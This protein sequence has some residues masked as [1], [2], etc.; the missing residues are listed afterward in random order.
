MENKPDSK[1][2][3][4]CR[5][6]TAIE[7]VNPVRARPAQIGIASRERDPMRMGGRWWTPDLSDHVLQPRLVGQSRFASVTE[8]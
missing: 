3:R 7:L 6:F 8:T 5:V 4:T 1:G 2:T